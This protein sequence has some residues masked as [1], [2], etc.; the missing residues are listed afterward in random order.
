MSQI[1][2]TA[3]EMLDL[4]DEFLAARH[5]DNSQEG[6]FLLNILTA[7][8]GPDASGPNSDWLKKRTT[9]PIRAAAFP[10]LYARTLTSH[11]VDPVL[12]S[13]MV[14]GGH[15]H[16]PPQGDPIFAGLKFDERHFFVHVDLAA[17]TLQVIG[18]LKP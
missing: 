11:D 13:G 10:K 17:G 15:F 6:A 2:K 16:L 5:D 3:A 4:I 14:M 1:P 18:K 8:R 7:L 9:S 12:I